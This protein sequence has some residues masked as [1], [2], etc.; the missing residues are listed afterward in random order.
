MDK[1]QISREL[2]RIAKELTSS[3]VQD[4]SIEKLEKKGF[5][6][7]HR[8]SQWGFV[9]MVKRRSSGWVQAEVDESG[10]VNGMPVD[11][12]LREFRKM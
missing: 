2:L 3:D 8:S 6:I 11:K 7:K 9:V 10:D 5:R 1:I 12:Y 4:E